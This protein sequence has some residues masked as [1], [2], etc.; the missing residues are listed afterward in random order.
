MWGRGKWNFHHFGGRYLG[1]VPGESSQL[2]RQLDINV[3]PETALSK[4][5]KSKLRKTLDV[6]S[7]PELTPLQLGALQSAEEDILEILEDCLNSTSLIGTFPNFQHSSKLV[8]I[9]KVKVN[10]DLSH[11]DV[12]WGS[13]ILEAFVQRVYETRGKHEGLRMRDKI[14]KKTTLHLQKREGTFRT[15]LMRSVDFRRV[16]RLMLI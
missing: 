2:I 10:R 13:T 16:P 8:H 4:I 5:G 11:I 14:F 12:I 15:F 9:S 3:S 6:Q 1:M 7:S